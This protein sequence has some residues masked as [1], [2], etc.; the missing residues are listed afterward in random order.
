MS[1][2]FKLAGSPQKSPPNQDTNPR[3]ESENTR[4]RLRSGEEKRPPS[5]EPFRPREKK[6]C[7][8]RTGFRH[9]RIP[10]PTSKVQGPSRGS[11][12]GPGGSGKSVGADPEPA[13]SNGQWGTPRGCPNAECG[14]AEPGFSRSA[15]R[16]RSISLAKPPRKNQSRSVAP[17]DTLNI[18][19]ICQKIM[20]AGLSSGKPG[21]I[22]SGASLY[23]DV[24][25]GR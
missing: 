8:G 23:G 5:P 3:G 11:D 25:V 12:K 14:M 24:L 4:Y 17:P 20:R 22:Q 19:G 7:K 15:C 10:R 21:R 6:P 9:R 16:G 13:P 18:G 1:Y 2:E